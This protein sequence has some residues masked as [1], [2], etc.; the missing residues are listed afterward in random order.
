MQEEKPLVEFHLDHSSGVAPYL[1]I[2]QQV[3]Q[4][5][6]LGFLQP[7]DQLPSMREVVARLTI[8]PNTVMKAYH[9]LEMEGLVKSRPGKGMFVQPVPAGPS[10]ATYHHFQ[11]RLADWFDDAY[12]AGLDRDRIEA[13]I[14]TTHYQII[15][16]R[17]EE[18]A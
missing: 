7:G 4:Y 12:A 17:R 8:N 11:Q 18:S 9:E 6:S 13:L 1:Q 10:V 14:T 15:L 3:K 2:V 5:L 16:R